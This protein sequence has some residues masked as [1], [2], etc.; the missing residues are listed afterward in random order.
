M[1]RFPSFIDPS[2]VKAACA[3]LEARGASRDRPIAIVLGTGLSELADGVEDAVRIPYETI[4]YFPQSGVSG[5]ASRIVM[6]TIE[7]R[8]VIMLQG[9]V[10]YYESGD[11]RAMALPL[12]ALAQLGVTRILFTSAAGGLRSD[13]PPG[14]VVSISDHIAFQGVNPLI[15]DRGDERFLPMIE[16]YS[17]ALRR[18]LARGAAECGEKLPEGVYMWFSGPSF[19]TPAEVR[20][21]KMLGADLVGMST[22]PEVILARRMGLEVAGLSLVTNYG[23]GMLGGAPNH[24]ETKRVGAA[25]AARLRRILR[26][27]IKA[28]HAKT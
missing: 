13:W 6:G 8:R 4:P 19:E 1:S 20:M 22:V 3:M 21:A 23:A 7:G 17:P 14:T 25:G 2:R 18:A 9:R 28:A 26:G 12:A 24:E 15:G 16:A 27:F 5:H 11:P 10:H